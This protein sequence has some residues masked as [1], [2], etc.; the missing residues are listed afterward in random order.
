[1]ERCQHC[2]DDLSTA[3][4]LRRHIRRKHSGQAWQAQAQ[5]RRAEI[6]RREPFPALAMATREAIQRSA[7]P[8][9]SGKPMPEKARLWLQYGWLKAMQVKIENGLASESECEQYVRGEAEY[10]S[11]VNGRRIAP[12]ITNGNGSVSYSPTAKQAEAEDRSLWFFLP[13]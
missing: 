9:T 13:G 1:M 7:E 4:N 6:V 11:V 5:P 8:I 12:K 3:F 2:G 10:L